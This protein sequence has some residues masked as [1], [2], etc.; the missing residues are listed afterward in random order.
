MSTF[1]AE[2]VVKSYTMKLCKPPEKVFPLL[3][4]VREYDWIEPWSCDMVFSQTGVAENNAVF[5]TN[6]AAQGGEETW[7]VIRYEKNKAI[8]FIR[9]IEGFKINRL[10]I[11]LRAEQS[12][13]IARWTHT[14]TGL[15][16]AGNRWIRNISDESFQSEKKAIEQMLNHYL[17]TGTMLKMRDLEMESDPYDPKPVR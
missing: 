12:K 1:K 4:P 10:D 6:F 7:V 13:T 11:A 9:M 15:S 5:R 17:E 16:D 3:C 2:R 14:Y 8:E